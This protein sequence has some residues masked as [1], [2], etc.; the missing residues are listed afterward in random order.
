MIRTSGSVPDART[1]TRPAS[2][3][4]AS[5]SCTQ[6]HSAAAAVMS[7]VRATRTFSS[8]CGERVICAASADSRVPV[9]T[10]TSHEQH[11]REQSVARCREVRVHDVARLLATHREIA[12]LHLGDDMAITDR[13]LDHVDSGVAQGM[14][15]SEV[16]HHGHDDR[17]AAQHAALVHVERGDRHDLVAVDDARRA[18]RP[19]SPGRRRRRV[20]ARLPRRA[21]VP[22]AAANRDVSIR[23]RH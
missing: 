17:V 19:R 16:R 1:S 22:H 9:R 3:K 10:S 6:S 14:T 11:R 13:R 5:T 21:R 15:H 2:P 12:R 4:L 18:R 20:R 23:T 8:S 7:T